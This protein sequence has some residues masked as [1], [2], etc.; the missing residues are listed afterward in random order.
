M[1]KLDKMNRIKKYKSEEFKGAL[2]VFVLLVVLVVALF[3]FYYIYL[4]PQEKLNSGAV[5]YKL[6]NEQEIDKQG[7]SEAFESVKQELLEDEKYSSLKKIGTWPLDVEKIKNE[8][9]DPFNLDYSN[10]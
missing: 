5:L 1:N 2:A 3:V 6:I 8:K 7:Q 4:M 9:I 10:E